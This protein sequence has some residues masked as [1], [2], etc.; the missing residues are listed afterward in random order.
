M[1]ESSKQNSFKLSFLSL[2]KIRLFS[3]FQQDNFFVGIDNT[4]SGSGF[5]SDENVVSGN[6]FGLD[7]RFNELLHSL[8]GVMLEFIFKCY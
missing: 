6:H 2:D 8:V 4:C 3:A 7:V 5:D 1:T